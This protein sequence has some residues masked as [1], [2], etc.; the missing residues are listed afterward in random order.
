MIVSQYIECS[1]HFCSFFCAKAVVRGNPA[2]NASKTAI[3]SLTESLVH[4]LHSCPQVNVT[5]HLFMYIHLW[6]ILSKS[7][8][9]NGNL[10]ISSGNMW[11]G[12]TCD[13]KDQDNI[14]EKSAQ[15]W[16]AL[17]T[18]E[19]ML[20]WVQTGEFYILVPDNKS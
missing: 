18:V 20:E 15:V 13:R 10:F 14:E 19:C 2:Y 11:M 16:T 17:E 3:K 8:D 7:V 6:H 12:M 5:A 1:A 4:E 9:D